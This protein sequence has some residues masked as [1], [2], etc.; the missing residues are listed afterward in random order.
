MD[1]LGWLISNGAGDIEGEGT[2]RLGDK[3]QATLGP[4]ELFRVYCVPSLLK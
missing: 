3:S 2:V 1:F 4:F